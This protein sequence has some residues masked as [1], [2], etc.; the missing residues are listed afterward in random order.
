LL[1]LVAGLAEAADSTWTNPA[2]GLWSTAGNWSGAIP[3]G[4]DDIARI[5]NSVST[6]TVTADGL[7]SPEVT[8]GSLYLDVDA[9]RSCWLKA[10]AGLVSL[11]LDTTSPGG[12]ALISK[13]RSGSCTVDACLRLRG[14]LDVTAYGS[15]VLGGVLSEDARAAR[16]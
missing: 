9:G 5:T 1:L 4:P 6:L 2:G 16:P 14:P 11:V 8:V 13:A 15:L 12:S 7:L 3:D 10:D